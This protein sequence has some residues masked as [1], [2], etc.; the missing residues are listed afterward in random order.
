MGKKDLTGKE[1][2]SFPIRFAELMNVVLYNGAA[3]VNP[4]DLERK[5][6]AYPSPLRVGEKQRDILM[7]DT[8]RKVCYG[9]ELETEADYSMPERVMVYDACEWERQIRETAGRRWQEGGKI[10]YRDKKSRLGREDF[11]LPVVT[12]VVYLGS[13]RWQGKRK[14]SELYHIPK[15][16]RALLEEKLPDY[17]FILMEADAVNADAFQTDL[18]EFFQAMQCRRDKRKLHRLL[19]SEAFHN[20]RTDTKWAI[21]V[22]LD[23]EKMAEKMEKEG[24]TMCQAI[25]ELMED[26]RK[27]GRIEGRE[28]GRIE[29]REEGREEGRI[30]G[31]VEGRKEGIRQGLEEGRLALLRQMLINGMDGAF[32]QKV[33]SC[34]EEELAMA[35]R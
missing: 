19:Q 23:R 35:E 17:S 8:A 27:E 3:V 31:R 6:A 7:L 24:M 30:E 10:T 9:M 25:D 15:E 5:P 29:G 28:E 1:F 33:T 4:A 20:L 26:A 22:Y 21:A 34:T 11:L 16:W 12:V 13:G 32:I 14:M 18:K 2:F